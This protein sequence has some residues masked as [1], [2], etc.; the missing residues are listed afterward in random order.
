MRRRRHDRGTA[1]VV[2]LVAI[3]GGTL[4]P[5]VLALGPPAWLDSFAGHL[6]LYGGAIAVG[7]G[8]Y[9]RAHRIYRAVL[10]AANVVLGLDPRVD[11]IEARS[12]RIEQRQ[13]RIEKHLGIT[14]DPDPLE[15]TP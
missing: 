14:P 1:D 13:L 6:V 15:D 9:K 3:L 4:I 7:W 11:R 12:D 5:A 8:I 10:D 2:L